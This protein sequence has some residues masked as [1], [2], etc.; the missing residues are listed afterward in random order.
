MGF[1]VHTVE[2]MN[3]GTPLSDLSRLKAAMLT[4]VAIV[5]IIGEMTGGVVD[6]PGAGFTSIPTLAAVG[7]TGGTITPSMAVETTSAGAAGVTYAP[8]DTV[9]ATGG[10][11]SQQA[12]VEV[13]TT[14][15]VTAP[16]VAVGGSGYVVGD[17]ITLQNGLVVQVATLST[18]A[19]ATVTIVSAG[20]FTTNNTT[21]GGF[22][23]IS[24]TGAGTGA[25]FTMT[26]AKYGVNTFQVQNAGAYSVLA[27]SPLAQGST[28]GSG[29][30]FTLG[31]SAYQVQSFTAVGGTGYAD[32]AAVTATG[33]AGT[34]FAGTITT[35]PIGEPVEVTV[36]GFLLPPVYNVQITPN[37]PCA[38]GITSKTQTGF[39]VTF[40]PLSSSAPL[41]AT[42]FDA[43]ITA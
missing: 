43:L 36:S 19:V 22:T 11:A 14:K 24:T 25:T 6:N 3:G 33:G 9:T 23:Q 37:A 2:L 27:S 12:I 10:T 34:G 31:V 32:G 20:S 26:A 35:G 7:G 16:A 39:T 41:L 42:A 38:Y 5:A 30:G 40:E 13:L 4:G 21:A 18:S 1:P 29:T 15:A 28:S 17:Q 8:G